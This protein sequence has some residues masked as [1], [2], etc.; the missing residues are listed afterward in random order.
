MTRNQYKKAELG[1]YREKSTGEIIKNPDFIM[2][3][4]IE[5]DD[6]ADIDEIKNFGYRQGE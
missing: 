1:E 5:V 6:G 2:T 4:N 3:W